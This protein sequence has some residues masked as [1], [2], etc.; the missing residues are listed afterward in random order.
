MKSLTYQNQ[1]LVALAQEH[2]DARRPVAMMIV[3]A[4]VNASTSAQQEKVLLALASLKR[5]GYVGQQL[6]RWEVTADGRRVARQMMAGKAKPAAAVATEPMESGFKP[7]RPRDT[8]RQAVGGAPRPITRP[9]AVPTQPAVNDSLT[10]DEPAVPAA[11]EGAV[12]DHFADVR[13]MVPPLPGELLERCAAMHLTLLAQSREALDADRPGAEQ[14][15]AWLLE[16]GKQLLA[17][18]ELAQ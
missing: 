5:Q 16:T 6:D 12:R 14:E 10:T 3:M 7:R 2:E 8:L 18:G 17:A 4:A 11:S 15:L 1:V 9:K 13:N